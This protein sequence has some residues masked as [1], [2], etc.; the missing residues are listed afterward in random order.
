M[1]TLGWGFDSTFSFVPT[2]TVVTN[3]RF[4]DNYQSRK[5]AIGDGVEKSSNFLGAGT[6]Y[7]C[8]NHS[9]HG[10]STLKIKN[11]SNML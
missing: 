10:I 7:R 8:D 1:W 9:S 5:A 11:P 3:I 6:S 4:R 2:C